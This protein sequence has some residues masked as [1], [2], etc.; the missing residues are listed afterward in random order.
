MKKFENGKKNKLMVGLLIVLMCLGF[1]VACAEPMGFGF[2]NAKDVAL[3]RGIGGKKVLARLPKNTCV[4]I[5]GSETDKKGTEWFHVNA[6]MKIKGGSYDYTG[7][8]KAEFIDAGEKV[9][10]NIVSVSS[11]N[12]GMIALRAD[13]TAETAARPIMI[14]PTVDKWSAGRGWTDRFESRIVQVQALYNGFEVLTEEGDIYINNQ[15][16]PIG[17]G[18]RLIGEES[19]SYA[20]S[21]EN[22]FRSIYSSDLKWVVPSGEPDAEQVRRV[23]KLMNEPGG[24]FMLTDA[25]DTLAALEYEPNLPMPDWKD[26]TGLRTLSVRPYSPGEGL[27]YET[28]MGA[29]I[30]KDGS[31]LTWPD[32]VT[33]AVSGWEDIKEVKL[34]QTYILGLK[35]DGTAITA[36]LR[37]G[38][39]PDVSHWTDV[40]GIET[41]GTYCVG[42]RQDGTLVFAGEHVFMGDGKDIQ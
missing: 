9:W 2:V 28:W 15:M 39:A 31:L 33:S 27:P 40:I 16:S 26:W 41:D 19:S 37:G 4:W 3:R 13:G 32:F 29:G 18:F 5:H 42:I 8:M 1:A 38:A 17:R 24:I 36:G 14:A 11:N 30:R 6:G 21:N 12:W 25:G 22:A 35:T 23:I 34:A 10:N 7:W 20:L